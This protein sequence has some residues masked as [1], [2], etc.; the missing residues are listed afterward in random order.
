[1]LYS[2]FNRIRKLSYK[3]VRRSMLRKSV[4]MIKN[5]RGWVLVDCLVGIII[6]TVALTALIG[7]YAQATKANIFNRDYNN[8]VYI[9]K[10]SLEDLKQY[11]GKPDIKSLPEHVTSPP[12]TV[13]NNVA[14]T[15]RIDSAEAAGLDAK[16]NPYRATVSWNGTKQSV[17]MVSYYLSD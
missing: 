12:D 5:Q 4:A 7:A 3:E 1:M 2:I 17:S 8:A 10:R 13:I 14:F 15:I 16:I 11:E 6:I 9:A